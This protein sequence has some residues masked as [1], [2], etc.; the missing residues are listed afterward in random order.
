ME[1]FEY[2]LDESL[3]KME[4][5]PETDYQR[6]IRLHQEHEAKMRKE[7]LNA[8]EWRYAK[9]CAT[10][11]HIKCVSYMDNWHRCYLE[12]DDR[13]V[14]TYENHVCNKHEW[15]RGMKPKSW[16]RAVL[17]RLRKVY[18]QPWNIVEGDEDSQ[19]R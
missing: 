10:C 19:R 1:K 9:C 6:S 14:K 5:I 13:S 4:D 12:G 15:Q 8:N 2:D 18:D 16:V 17:S 11:K 3:D 7:I